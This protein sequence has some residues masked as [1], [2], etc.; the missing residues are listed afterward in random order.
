M[1]SDYSNNY[2]NSV[3][4]PNPQ[5][6]LNQEQLLHN[7]NTNSIQSNSFDSTRTNMSAV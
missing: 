2:L 1:T 4:N 5:A 7:Q 3:N 6:Q